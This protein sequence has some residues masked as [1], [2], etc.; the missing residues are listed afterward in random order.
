MN[1]NIIL[2]HTEE[3]LKGC[4]SV[5]I[6]VFVEEQQVPPDLEMDEFDDSWMACRHFLATEGSKP[7][8]AARWRMYDG[9]TA[10]LQRIAVLAS[11][12]GRGIGRELIQ[13][14]EAD[15]R[16]QGVP[17]VILDA[18]TQAESF[19]RKLGYETI[20]PEPFIDAGIWHVRMRK[21]LL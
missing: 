4:F 9:Q 15:I 10:K 21:K 17:A 20:S 3:Q 6:N 16:A 14:M 7:V 5:R 12:R 2:V 13:A 8:G 1:L 19:Y 11:Y 18:Q